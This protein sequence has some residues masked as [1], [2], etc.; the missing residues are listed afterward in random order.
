MSVA[1]QTLIDLRHDL[2]ART[3]RAGKNFGIRGTMKPGSWGFHFGRGEIY[4]PIGKGDRDYS[5]RH[6][7]NKA[8][9]TNSSSGFDI[10]LP[11]GQLKKLV[12]YLIDLQATGKDLGMLY[13]VIGPD[14]AGKATR[15]AVDTK[16]KPTDG[17]NDHEWHIHIGWFRDTEFRDKRPLFDAFF[18]TSTPVP[19]PH[20][21]LR[22]GATG[23]PV[24]EL[25][26]RLAEHGHVVVAPGAAGYGTFGPLTDTAVRAFQADNEFVVDGI[27]HAGTWDALLADPPMIP[28]PGETPAPVDP[29]QPDIPDD[30][31]AEQNARDAM[32]AI[33]VI[34]AA[35]TEGT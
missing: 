25:Q 20:P 27:V 6:V 15:W 28:E 32:A 34:V 26:D 21:E 17:S 23:D 14:A 16:W 12:A 29:Q 4:G 35:Y 5:V 9:L 22:L 30:V 18:A 24:R 11:V 2:A 31:V 1:P 8:G 7:R 33:A 10:R 3:G 13:E 19:D